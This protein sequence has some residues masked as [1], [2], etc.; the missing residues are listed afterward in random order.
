MKLDDK[1][2]ALGLGCL[3]GRRFGITVFMKQLTILLK[4]EST[5]E[6]EE[7]GPR[8]PEKARFSSSCKTGPEQQGTSYCGW[9]RSQ[10]A[11][12]EVVFF[13]EEHTNG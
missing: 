10:E 6:S 9:E 7:S 3:S 5:L 2:V 11:S 12:T 13:R 1:G 4:K 8:I